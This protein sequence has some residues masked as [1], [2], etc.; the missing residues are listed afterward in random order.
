MTKS[1]LEGFLQKQN[2]SKIMSDYF[3]VLDIRGYIYF[4]LQTEDQELDED[5]RYPDESF[6]I[7]GCAN[8]NDKN[9]FQSPVILKR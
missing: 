2:A 9:P 4:F 5:Q 7:R 1:V 6:Y 3:A 8:L